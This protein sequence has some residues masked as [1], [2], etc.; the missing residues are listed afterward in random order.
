MD[1]THVNFIL[2]V[3]G[4][5]FRLSE[6]HLNFMYT[7][8]V[9][10]ESTK[11]LI[12]FKVQNTKHSLESKYSKENNNLVFSNIVKIILNTNNNLNKKQ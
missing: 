11:N 1:S 7:G 2:S 12:I 9:I 8:R 5:I 10:W 3:R 6:T 4:L